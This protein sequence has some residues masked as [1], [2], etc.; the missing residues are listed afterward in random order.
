MHLEL[1]CF[2]ARRYLFHL[3]L[4]ILQDSLHNTHSFQYLDISLLTDSHTSIFPT[5]HHNGVSGSTQ[6]QPPIIKSE[7]Q[8][9]FILFCSGESTALHPCM[10]RCLSTIKRRCSPSPITS[11]FSFATTWNDNLR[12]SIFVKVAVASTV[13]PSLLGLTC[14]APR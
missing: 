7:L 3:Y 11:P 14:D 12:R 4:S 10:K 13:A 5:Q 1:F 2:Q 8:K 6:S 9:S